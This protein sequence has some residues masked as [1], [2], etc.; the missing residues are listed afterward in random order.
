MPLYEVL[1]DSVINNHF[2]RA[3]AIVEFDGEPAGNLAPVDPQLEAVLARA[4]YVDQVG[5]A[6]E[7]LG[8]PQD[9][10]ALRQALAWLMRPRGLAHGHP[11]G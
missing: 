5:A 2:V 4:N 3:G 11:V 10:P 8:L 1:A 7:A 9:H 6:Q